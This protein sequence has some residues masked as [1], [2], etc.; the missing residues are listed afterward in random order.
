[1][2]HRELSDCRDAHRELQQRIEDLD[3]GSFTAGA[4]EDTLDGIRRARS[5]GKVV[6]SF[7]SATG[8]SA[9]AELLHGRGWVHIAAAAAALFTTGLLVMRAPLRRG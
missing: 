8:S 2:D 4:I 3:E 6:R 1:M 7:T 5:E 9:D